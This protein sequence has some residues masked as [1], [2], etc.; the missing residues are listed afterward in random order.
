MIVEL[1]RG[2]VGCRG[3]TWGVVDRR[4]VSWGF[5]GQ[6]FRGQTGLTL[7]DTPVHET[8][9]ES[10]SSRLSAKLRENLVRVIL[11]T[12]TLL[13]WLPKQ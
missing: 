1:R 6:G 4:G 12:V 10:G 7:S 8:Q 11:G 5:R 9:R 2:F 13:S 3:Q